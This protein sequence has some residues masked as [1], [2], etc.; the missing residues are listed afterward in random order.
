MFRISNIVLLLIFSMPALSQSIGTLH[1]N[2]LHIDLPSNWSFNSSS[3]LIEGSTLEG[4]LLQISILR[5]RDDASPLKSGEEILKQGILEHMQMMAEKDGGTVKRAM[6]Q[7]PVPDGKSGYSLAAQIDNNF[8]FNQ[9]A[10]A[11]DGVAIYITYQGKGDAIDAANKFDKYL[12][13]QRWD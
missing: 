3:N 6:K 5:Q 8:Y 2:P 7:I 11:T 10:L 13:S 9:Y 4:E 12:L 1:L